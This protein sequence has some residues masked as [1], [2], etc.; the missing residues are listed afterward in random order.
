MQIFIFSFHMKNCILSI[1][2]KALNAPTLGILNTSKRKDSSSP[3]GV[4]ILMGENSTWKVV[5]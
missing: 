2:Q 3:Q 5:E 4:C 1:N